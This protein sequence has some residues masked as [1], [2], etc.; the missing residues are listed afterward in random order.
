MK[1]C[2]K[3][4]RDLVAALS[5]DFMILACTILIGLNGVTDTRTHRPTDAKTMA[6]TREAF[7][8]RA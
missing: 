3:K 1:F 7:C 6:E 2:R 8:C 5:Q 4:T